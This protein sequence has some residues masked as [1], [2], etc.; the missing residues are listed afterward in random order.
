MERATDE[1]DEQQARAVAVLEAAYAGAVPFVEDRACAPE[2]AREAAPVLHALLSSR[3]LGA[4][5]DARA[6]E[7]HEAL[8]LVLLLGRRAGALGVTPT[9]ALALVRALSAALESV[10]SPVGAEFTAVVAALVMEGYVAAREERLSNLSAA[11]AADALP[12]LRL[13]PKCLALVLS[14]EHEPERLRD[15]VDRFGRALFAADARACVVDLSGL[16][17]PSAPL[18]AEAFAADVAARML[19]VTCIF[20]GVSPAWLDAAKAARVPLEVLA[21]EP[22]FEVALARALELAGYALKPE[23]RL[24]ALFKR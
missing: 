22:T 15:V 24:R 19:G 14:G 7:H 11:Q 6:L 3:S 17:R 5:E 9:A 18:A 12:T 10:G 2:L 20:C 23:G 4:P 13:A 8:A 21:L 1:I 16:R